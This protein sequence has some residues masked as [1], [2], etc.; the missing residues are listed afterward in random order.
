MIGLG[1]VLGGLLTW[2]CGTRNIR[3][4]AFAVTGSMLPA[5]ALSGF[6]VPG[7]GVRPASIAIACVVGLAT[8]AASFYLERRERP[9]GTGQGSRGKRGRSRADRGLRLSAACLAASVTGCAAGPAYAISAQK[10]LTLLQVFFCLLAGLVL[11]SCEFG[12]LRSLISEL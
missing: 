1:I 10:T 8:L 5:L 3:W 7:E 12:I 11:A 4:C 6:V 9:G 2:A